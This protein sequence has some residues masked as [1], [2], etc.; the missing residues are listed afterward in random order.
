MER[1]FVSD[2]SSVD[3]VRFEPKW[4]TDFEIEYTLSTTVP[5]LQPMGSVDA[6]NS[7]TWCV[8]VVYMC[9][10]VSVRFFRVVHELLLMHSPN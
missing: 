8:G 4:A 7:I 1:V 10:C 9:A 6:T 5:S 3:W 2:G